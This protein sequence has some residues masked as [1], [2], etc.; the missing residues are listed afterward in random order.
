MSPAKAFSDH[1]FLIIA[2]TSKAGTTSVFNYLAKHPEICATEVKETRFFLDAD[3]PLRSEMRYERNGA[4]AYHSFFSASA[5]GSESDWRLEATPDYLYS[6]GAA[7]RIL[8][9]LPNIRLIF[10]LREPVSRLISFYRFGQ[11]MGEVPRSMCFDEFLQ[12]QKGNAGGGRANTHRHPVFSALPHGCYSTYLRPFFELFGKSRVHVAFHED[13]ARAPLEVME[14]VCHFVQID[15][16][17]FKDYSFEVANK[18]VSVRSSSLHNAYWL[19]KQKIR[20]R[21]RGAPKVRSMLR[22]VG[23]KID[24]IYEKTNVADEGRTI[25]SRS[26]EEFIRGYYREEPAR[27]QEML[28]H[29]VPWSVRPSNS[30]VNKVTR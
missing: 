27:L 21:L 5:G 12:G 19:T 17:Y 20:S 18:G 25:M 26:T 3:Y 11:A 16:R 14:A 9:T 23:S 29:E 6:P 1:R 24:A 30:E 13:L 22:R 28:G 4:L 8:E 15:E 10:L 7:R 2:G